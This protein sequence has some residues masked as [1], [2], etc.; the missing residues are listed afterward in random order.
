MASLR[1]CFLPM[2]MLFLTTLL[3]FM[4]KVVD[5]TESLS[6]SFSEFIPSQQDLVFQGDSSVSST[7]RLQ[8]TVVKDGRPIS[9]T[10]RALY[11]APVH[12]WD[13]KTGNV[14]SFVTSFSFIINA[15]NTT[16]DGLAFFLAPVDTQLQNSGGFLGLYP[17]QD[18]SK[19]YQVV[20]VEFDTFLNSWDSTTPHIGIDVNSIKSLIVGSWDFQNGQVANVVISYQASTKQLTASLVYP[21][22]LARIISAMA[23]LKSVLPEFV[24]VGFS[25]SSGAF[26]ESHDVLSWSFQSKL[27]AGS[28]G[29]AAF[30]KVLRT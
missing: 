16:A 28:K 13:N 9:S 23:D 1:S 4:N 3:F 6:F 5:S 11:A 14:A 7:G 22:G 18:E 21:S 29:V 25:A 26:V 8:L 10:G 20:A 12:I 2:P 15:P 27:P 19:S 17:N 30:N 24:R